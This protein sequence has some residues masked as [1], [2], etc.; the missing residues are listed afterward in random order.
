[1]GKPLLLKGA[2]IVDADGERSG[3]VLVERG[4]IARVGDVPGGDYAVT[5]AQGR[6]LTPGLI[7]C[8]VHL[9]LDAGP[10]VTT[11]TRRSEAEL[12]AL[13]LA[14]AVRT[15]RGGVTTARE[16]GTA[17]FADAAVKRVLASGVVQ[18]PRLLTSGYALTTTGGHGHFLGREADTADELVK[19]AREQMRQ[20]AEWLKVIA[21]GGV[22]TEG[23]NLHAS[24][25]T[26]AQLQALVEEAR[27]AGRGVA[28][29][30]HG[31][32]GIER[33]VQAGVAS[34]EH[35]T[36][37]S[38]AMA[39]QMRAKG[40]FLV[41]TAAAGWHI[42]EGGTA[43]G[44]PEDAVRKAQGAMKHHKEAVQ[45]ALAK[46]VP[47]AMGTDA[48]TPFNAHGDNAREV[49]LLVGYGMKPEQALAAA[50]TDAAR[51]LKLD[52]RVGRVRA[53]FEADLL[54]LGRNPLD[55]AAAFRQSLE[56]VM[57]GGDWVR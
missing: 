19:A 33:A 42:V 26:L 3:D 13:A 20:G 32:Q 51:L 37:L 36:Y 1:M 44:I 48:G 39:E 23:A 6:F 10:D 56:H 2:T 22:L 30:A 52:Q 7:D 11:P 16:V 5:S 21:T 46:S 15:L 12:G 25:Y 54:L 57:V 45:R 53:G 14:H 55:D 34:I 38:E 9:T 28:A 35:G 18:G 50:T 27:R 49:E 41:P 31:E 47:I 40:T 17:K 4:R 8:H 43:R 29:H 24:Q